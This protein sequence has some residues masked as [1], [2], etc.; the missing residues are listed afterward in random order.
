MICFFLKKGVFVPP[1][2][3]FSHRAKLSHAFATTFILSG[4]YSFGKFFMRKIF[5]ASPDVFSVSLTFLGT[6][7]FL[8]WVVVVRNEPLPAVHTAFFLIGGDML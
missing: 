8:A 5:F 6:T 1:L 3:K 4:F 7:I 2:S